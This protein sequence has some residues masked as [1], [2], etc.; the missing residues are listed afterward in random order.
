MKNITFPSF[1]KVSIVVASFFVQSASAQF[2]IEELS[3]GAGLGYTGYAD[4]IG[5]SLSVNIRGNYE[6]SERSSLVIGF[7]TQ[8]PVKKTYES[9]GLALSNMTTP[10]S[11]PV[12]VEQSIQFYNIGVA[13]NFYFVRDIE[14][15]FG[16]YAIVGGSISIAN[17]E[18]STSAYNKGM[19]D[20]GV[21]EGSE[22]F[23][24]I[25]LD[26]GVGTNIIATD[27]VHIFGEAKIGYPSGNEYNSRGNSVIVNP[28]PLN[29]SLSV[30]ARFNLFD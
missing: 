5:G 9:R 19:Y 2:D 28:L 29:Y 22:S 15:S 7:N 21:T 23:S 25:M 4:Q 18:L 8:L 12:N 11:V 14:E 1:L 17:R 26:L 3:L 27:L 30:G 6:F 16:M 20:A 24:G 13:Y 10:Y